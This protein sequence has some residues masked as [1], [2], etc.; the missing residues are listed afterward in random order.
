MILKR[1]LFTFLPLFVGIV[2]HTEPKSPQ[3]IEIQ[4]ALQAAAY[5][6]RLISTRV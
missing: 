6:V 2:A 4:R 5:H 1:T 3:E